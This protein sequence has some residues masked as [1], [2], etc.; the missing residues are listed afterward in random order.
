MPLSSLSMR[1][2][3]NA[4]LARVVEIEASSYGFPWSEGI[5][6]DCLRVGYECRV[7][8]LDGMIVGYGILSALVREAH[9]L[10]LCLDNRYR[11]M[12]LGRR[13]LDHLL[14]LAVQ[15]N[16][17][18]VFLEVRPSNQAALSLYGDSGFEQVGRRHNYYRAR[19]GREDALV[20]RIELPHLIAQGRFHGPGTLLG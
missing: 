20:L 11:R 2:M 4:D 5:F 18:E 19:D 3:V 10:N 17:H 12:G 8:V 7:I 15:K 6:R 9:I 1:A 14:A 13:L 16:V